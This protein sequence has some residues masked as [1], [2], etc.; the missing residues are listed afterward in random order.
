MWAVDGLANFL[1]YAGLPLLLFVPVAMRIRRRV[2]AMMLAL[3]AL[4]YVL[5]LLSPNLFLAL[6]DDVPETSPRLR[7]VTAN[8]LMSNTDLDRLAEDILA[9][10]PDVVVFE[11]LTRAIEAFSPAL[12]AAYPHRV[13]TEVPW[14]TL[15]SRWPLEDAR[16][17]PIADGDRARDLL[18]ASVV[19]GGTRVSLVA[20]HFMPPLDGEA[21][22]TNAAQRAVLQAE[23]D[24]TPG[25]LMVVGDFNATTLSPSFARLLSGTGLRIATSSRLAEPTYYAYGRFGVRIDHV[26]VRGVTVAEEAAFD[27]TGSDH[28]GLVVE[29]G[30]PAPERAAATR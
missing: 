23:V 20:V 3:P 4:L 16:V 27:L 8:V 22:R 25:P 28:R 18:A 6:P 13:A 7:V 2:L 19:V 10:A 21:Y 9:Q 15:A 17:L 30:L 14:V 24:A 1:P 11:E 29:V 12:A 26:L 5:V